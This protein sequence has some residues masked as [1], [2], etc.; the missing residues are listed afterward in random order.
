MISG[1]KTLV[2]SI[3]NMLKKLVDAI[4]ERNDILYRIDYI[5]NSKFNKNSDKILAIKEILK[6]Y[7]KLKEKKE[8]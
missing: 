5:A 8:K 4:K 6:D 3:S 2:E 7:E 1:T